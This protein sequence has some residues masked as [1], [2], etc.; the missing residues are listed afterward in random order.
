MRNG[1]CRSF[2]ALRHEKTAHHTLFRGALTH[3]LAH[4]F[5]YRLVSF[6]SLIHGFTRGYPCI[7]H[8]PRVITRVH[9]VSHCGCARRTDRQ[10]YVERTD[11]RTNGRTDG[12]TFGAAGRRGVCARE[13]DSER[14]RER[15]K[16]N[17]RYERIKTSK[18]LSFRITVSSLIIN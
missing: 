6:S 10:T 17:K 16:G 12:R 4:F 11:K 5:F 15:E 2:H 8:T 14:E 18:F 1:P 13:T 9:T 3:A 7:R